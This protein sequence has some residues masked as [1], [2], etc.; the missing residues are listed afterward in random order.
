MTIWQNTQVKETQE[1]R[2]TYRK[3]SPNP[4]FLRIMDKEIVCYR[5]NKH[6]KMRQFM[7]DDPSEDTP[8]IIG[9]ELLTIN[10]RQLLRS[11]HCHG[12]FSEYSNSTLFWPERNL[13]WNR[14]WYYSLIWSDGIKSPDC[15]DGKCMSS[16][17]TSG[18]TFGWSS[19]D[20]AV[21]CRMLNEG[22]S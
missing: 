3:G 14:P 5:G 6:Q 21:I 4:L 11:L 8:I 7:D 9:G 10:F 12:E 20:R 1:F 19:W 13:L 2:C 16:Y 18:S 22:L 15:M 17:S